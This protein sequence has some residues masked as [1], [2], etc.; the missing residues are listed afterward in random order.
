[1]TTTTETR[2]LLDVERKFWDAMQEK[3]GKTAGEM[4]DES[5]IVV[6]AQGVNRITAQEMDRMTREGPWQLT[7][8][9][10]KDDTAQVRMLGDDVALVAYSVHED[11][12]M[13]GKPMSM[14]AHEA[15]VWVRRDGEWRCALHVESLA[16]DDSSQTSERS[17]GTR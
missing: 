2:T 17:A 5:C 8:Y 10:L 15:S 3:D 9:D 12:T 11:V 16:G 13:N 4:T 1:M 7:G 6:G 14:D